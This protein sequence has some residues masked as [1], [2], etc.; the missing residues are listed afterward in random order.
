MSTLS[1]RK[2]KAVGGVFI[3]TKQLNLVGGGG[4]GSEFS[5]FSQGQW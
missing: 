5:G 2:G 3:L 1:R 4:G